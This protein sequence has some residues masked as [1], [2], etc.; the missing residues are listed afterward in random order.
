MSYVVFTRKEFEAYYIANSGITL[1]QLRS[2]G[3]CAIPCDCG[4]PEC[5]GWQMIHVEFKHYL[6]PLQRVI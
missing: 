1:A 4:A 6:M 2:L 3:R 5:R